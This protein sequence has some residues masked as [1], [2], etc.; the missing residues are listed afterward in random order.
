[1]LVRFAVSCALALAVSGALAQ[2]LPPGQ[3]PAQTSRPALPNPASVNCEK[4]GGRHVIRSLPRGQVGMC[5]FKDGR[6]CE[7]WALYRDD[8]C[9]GGVAPKR[10]SN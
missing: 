2:P 4:L 10:V 7:E 6:V 9:V 5:V 8:R 1:M 3:Q